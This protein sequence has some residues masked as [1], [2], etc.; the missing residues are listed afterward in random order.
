M[1]V[2]VK[3]VFEQLP[4]KKEIKYNLVAPWMKKHDKPERWNLE[5]D[6]DEGIYHSWNGGED[7]GA[8]LEDTWGNYEDNAVEVSSRECQS[9][10]GKLTLMSIFSVPLHAIGWPLL[11]GGFV[12]MF[13]ACP[14]KRGN[15][16]HWLIEDSYGMSVLAGL[17]GVII[18]CV[19]IFWAFGLIVERN[20]IFKNIIVRQ[21]L[22]KKFQVEF[23]ESDAETHEKYPNLKQLKENNVKMNMFLKLL[24]IRNG[25]W[26]SSERNDFFLAYYQETPFVFMDITL[27]N[28]VGTG[29]EATYYKQFMGQ[30]MLFPMRVTCRIEKNSQDQEMDAL[31]QRLESAYADVS[32]DLKLEMRLSA[33]KELPDAKPV[34]ECQWLRAGN[35][36][37]QVAIMP[38]FDNVIIPSKQENM[39]FS[40]EEWL[41]KYASVYK[42]VTHIA[43]CRVGFVVTQ[44]FL[45]VILE[46]NYDPF[47]FGMKDVFKNKDKKTDLVAK[48]VTWLGHICG[49]MK[50]AGLI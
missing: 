38:F 20:K 35:L 40:P 32:E 26:T 15:K 29:K 14:D 36:G 13:V 12:T 28:K 42:K 37:I 21:E 23:L 5:E 22:S 34:G 45:A 43:Q 19:M 47:E 17:A 50:N 24:S 31:F 3:S 11:I 48:Q 39:V 10:Y 9:I 16:G 46:N 33:L 49:T 2:D 4:L 44:N 30:V 1:G 18:A 25:G 7:S 41:E 6:S 27:T 8:S